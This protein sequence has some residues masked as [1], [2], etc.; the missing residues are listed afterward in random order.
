MK[1]V[2]ERLE[3]SHPGLAEFIRKICIC[4]DPKSRQLTSIPSHGIIAIKG[5][6]F[7]NSNGEVI[8][9][10]EP[11]RNDPCPCGSGEKYKKCCGR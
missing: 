10:P 7:M 1:I 5:L 6:D 9:A 11:G 8:K 2:I 3:N 4:Y